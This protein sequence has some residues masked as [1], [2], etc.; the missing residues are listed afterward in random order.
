MSKSC[1]WAQEHISIDQYGRFRPC[2]IWQGYKHEDQHLNFNEHSIQDYIDSEFKSNLN[3]RL[4]AD[5]WPGGCAMCKRVEN[6]NTMSLRT[7]RVRLIKDMEI[8]FGN[9]C[10]LAC[11]MCTSDKSSLLHKTYNDMIATGLGDERIS[12]EIEDLDAKFSKYPTQWY[13]RPE[14]LKEL[15]EYAA[16]RE[17]IRFTGGEPT[18]NTYL[19]RFLETLVELNTD[20]ILRITTNGMSM[21]PALLELLSK[22]KQVQLTFSIDGT[23]AY[24]EYLRYPSNWQKIKA[25][26]ERASTLDNVEFEINTVVSYLNVHC[27]DS[28]I[29]WG[30]DNP[31][32]KKHIFL[33]VHEPDIL[34]PNLAMPAQKEVFKQTVNKY[35]HNKSIE[36]HKCSQFVNRPRDESLVK[37]SWDFLDRL[38]KHR[39]TNWRELFGMNNEN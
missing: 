12:E 19:K 17:R 7:E 18:V 30:L 26:V 3:K 1:Y 20:I 34:A 25:N 13:D 23:D 22:F 35:Q 6:N 8:K 32:V 9:L 37:D 14:K 38:D 5:E 21:S 10:N 39:G 11:Y 16:T 29:E 31:L 36:L 28:V 24:N 27:L 33:P 15:A 4:D 2:C